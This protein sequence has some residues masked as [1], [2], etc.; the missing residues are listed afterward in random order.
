[1]RIRYSRWDGTQDP[2]GP[3]ISAADLLEEMSGELLSGQGS[4]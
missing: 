1:M 2:L 4:A 3:D